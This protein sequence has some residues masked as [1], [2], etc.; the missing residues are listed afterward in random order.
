MMRLLRAQGETLATSTSSAGK[1]DDVGAEKARPPTTGPG[2]KTSSTSGSGSASGG[3]GTHV[4]DLSGATGAVTVQPPAQPPSAGS[5]VPSGLEST[6]TS[7]APVPVAKSQFGPATGAGG[8]GLSFDLSRSFDEIVGL[9]RPRTNGTYGTGSFGSGSQRQRPQVQ[10]GGSVQTGSHG[11]ANSSSQQFPTSAAHFGHTPVGSATA[12]RTPPN[13][14]S[15]GAAAN[16]AEQLRN[17]LSQSRRKSEE[18]QSQSQGHSQGPAS[19]PNHKLFGGAAAQNQNPESS[20]GSRGAQQSTAS[21]PGAAAISSSAAAFHDADD[22]EGLYEEAASIPDSRLGSASGTVH[23][24]LDSL[25]TGSVGNVT[26]VGYGNGSAAAGSLSLGSAGGSLSSSSRASG[27]GGGG[28]PGVVIGGGSSSGSGSTANTMRPYRERVKIDR[29]VLER[30]RTGPDRAA[31][32]SAASSSSSSSF[33]QFRRAPPQPTAPSFAPRDRLLP[34]QGDFLNEDQMSEAGF[35]DAVMRRIRQSEGQG[36]SGSAGSVIDLDDVR[37]DSSDADRGGG[38]AD[39]GGSSRHH[40]DR[41]RDRDRDRDRRSRSRSRVRNRQSHGV[42]H[43]AS[44][45]A[46][47]SGHRTRDRDRDRSGASRPRSSSRPKSSGRV[48]TTSRDSRDAKTKK[49]GSSAGAGPPASSKT[50]EQQPDEPAGAS[51]GKANNSCVIC[52]TEPYSV[53]FVPCGHM[54]C[55]PGCSKRL[56]R[57]RDKKCPMCRKKITKAQS[58]FM[59]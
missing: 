46:S 50:A 27:V 15:A 48:P 52:W 21:A 17:L 26:N 1:K 4:T 54:C 13:P 58:V 51:G 56:M 37:I 44:S 36:P 23:A 43:A 40:R 34:S 35:L 41:E 2:S 31:S 22:G 19:A 30:G 18:G 14:P 25:G 20:S 10:Q 59:A 29:S 32:S 55:C 12:Q 8:G 24:S 7:G 38:G 53:V 33:Q 47:S 45:S 3:S 42:G 28:A 11:L 57:Q 6:S 49:A 9:G 16:S 39:G 5:A